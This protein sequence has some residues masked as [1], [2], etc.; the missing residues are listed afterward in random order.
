[1]DSRICCRTVMG[2]GSAAGG[3]LPFPDVA[4]LVRALA[5]GAGSRRFESCYSD[6]VPQGSCQPDAVS[7]ASASV[8]KYSLP[9]ACGDQPERPS[10]QAHTHPDAPPP[11]A[12]AGWHFGSRR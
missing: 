6:R 1:M 2:C 3:Y 7:A 5:L 11:L 8:R 9:S 12:H 10:R 4:Q